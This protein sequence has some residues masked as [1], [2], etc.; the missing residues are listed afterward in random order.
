M[1]WSQRILTA[2]F[3]FG[4][5]DNPPTGNLS[6]VVSSSAHNAFA[7]QAA[8]EGI[9]LLQNNGGLL[10]LGSTVHSIAVIGSVASVAPISTGAGSAGVNLP[11][12][13][14]PLAGIKSLAG[15]GVTVNYSQGD[16]ASITAAA[17]LAATN[18]VAIVC[19][20]QQT[21]EGSDRSSLSLPNGQDALISAVATANPHTIVVVYLDSAV[22]MPWASQAGAI[23]MAWYP[24]QENGNALAQLLF[25]GVNPSGKLPVTIPASSSQVPAS[26]PAQFPGVLGHTSYSEALQIGYRWY[27]ANN[28]A[29]LFPF[30]YGLSYT[31][32]GYGN[33]AISSVSP[34]GQVQISFNVT[35]TGN[36]AGAE[37]PELYPRLSRSRRRT[38]ASAKK[39]SAGVPF[40]RPEPAGDVQLDMGRPS[41]LGRDGTGLDCHARRFPGFGGRI[42]AGH[43]FERKFHRRFR[44]FK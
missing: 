29:P 20:G 44:S 21:S 19:V 11:Y 17:A 14:T 42:V 41:Q 9:V 43:P 34:S 26:T 39:I 37:I 32:F 38:A 16:G 36:V 18:D 5:F 3:Q 27:D 7:L 12:N 6:S 33:L 1:E 35:N 22:L 15:S 8:E 10:P 40:A 30:G 4:I 2:M 24:G 23:L 28:V 13:V 25:G 31:T